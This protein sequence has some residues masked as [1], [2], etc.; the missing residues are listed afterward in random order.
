[1]SDRI[2]VEHSEG[3][4]HV[5]LIRSEKM[6]ALDT[7]MFEALI[8]TGD[9]LK[10]DNSVRC[11][12]ISGQG[13]SFCAGLDMSNF[14]NFASGEPRQSLLD[15]T[16]DISNAFQYPVWVWRELQVPVIA[17]IHGV[18]VGGG[19]QIALAADM[20]YAAPGTKCSVMEIKWGLVPDMGG[21]QL[22]RG[23]TRDDV[24]RELSYTGRVFKAEEALEL[25]LVTGIADDPVSHALTLA[26]GIAGKNPD[27][28]RANKRLFNQMRYKDEAGGLMHESV[29]Q[30]NLIGQPNQIEAVMAQLENRAPNFS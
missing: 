6:N 25:G 10:Q 8:E 16:H 23:L 17:A 12:V 14:T 9:A 22:L 20:R 7:A 27:A 15:R 13:K 18:A 29:E 26:R 24:A 4:A 28:I 21:I 2:L 3:V 11:V 19:F 5:Q 1:M 30:E